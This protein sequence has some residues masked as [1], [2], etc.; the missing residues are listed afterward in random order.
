MNRRNLLILLAG[1]GITR[2]LAVGAEQPGMPVIG[3]LSSASAESFAPW[4]RHFAMASKTPA[5][6][7]GRMSPSNSLGRRG[8]TT[9]CRRSPGIWYAGRSPSSW[10][11]AGRSPPLRPRA[12]LP[13][14]RL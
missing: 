5:T 14:S 12:L 1:A 8:S 3:F 2:P 4:S 13:S 7:K 9:N 11:W 6:S 10:R